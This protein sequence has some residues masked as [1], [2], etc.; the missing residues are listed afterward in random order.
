MAKVGAGP[1]GG[2]GCGC[3]CVGSVGNVA[4]LVLCG[5]TST[6]ANMGTWIL[7]TSLAFM[8]RTSYHTATGGTVRP[9]LVSRIRG[10]T[11]FG[12]PEIGDSAAFL[13]NPGR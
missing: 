3:G 4:D 7:A 11:T 12:K 13:L 8:T 2:A 10:Y 6:P 9:R 5:R 1:G